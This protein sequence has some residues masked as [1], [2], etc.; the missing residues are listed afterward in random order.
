M[1]ATLE[2]D[3]ETIFEEV[4][5]LLR[6]FVPPFEERKDAKGGFHLWCP[7]PIVVNGRK[8]QDVYF[9][10][11]IQQKGHVGFYYMPVYTDPEQKAFFQPELLSLLKGKSC[12]HLKKPDPTVRKQIRERLHAGVKLYRERGWI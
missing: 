9:A 6:E 1:R 12:F 3:R 8:K 5:A 4:A 2:V 7:K 11:V 10:G